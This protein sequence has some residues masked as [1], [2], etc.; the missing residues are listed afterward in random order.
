M[1]FFSLPASDHRPWTVFES[2]AVS[3]ALDHIP[4]SAPTS[5]SLLRRLL[6]CALCLMEHCSWLR[7]LVGS[8]CPASHYPLHSNVLPCCVRLALPT[9]SNTYHPARSCMGRHV[10]LTFEHPQRRCV[11]Q[12][13][14]TQLFLWRTN[15]DTAW[16][17]PARTSCAPMFLPPITSMVLMWCGCGF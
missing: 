15:S 8:W 5:A 14:H 17:A 10:R 1:Q 3:A 16:A 9:H 2:L 4:V 11:R 12:R 6:H 13:L 7:L